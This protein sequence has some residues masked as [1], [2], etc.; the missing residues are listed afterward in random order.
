MRPETLEIIKKNIKVAEDRLKE[1]TADI[2]K[3]RRAGID[4]S[5][6]EKTYREL[7]RRVTLLKSVYLR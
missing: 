3:A 7:V 2:E 1:L 6:L 5:E 4:V